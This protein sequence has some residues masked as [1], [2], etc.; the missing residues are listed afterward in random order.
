MRCSEVIQELITSQGGRDDAVVAHLTT[1]ASCRRFADDSELLDRVWTQTRPVSPSLDSWAQVWDGIQSRLASGI[2]SHHP[3]V[4]A[5]PA[6]HKASSRFRRL[7]LLALAQAA[8]VLFVVQI[9][10]HFIPG[11][12]RD[13]AQKTQL[14]GVSQPRSEASPIEID[15]GPIVVISFAGDAREVVAADTDSASGVDDGFV[16]FNEIESLVTTPVVAYQE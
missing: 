15:E 9:G 16:L 3:T 7:G 2:E 12:G 4:L 11:P 13:A 6:T 14:A 10:W 1:C 8:A 5:M